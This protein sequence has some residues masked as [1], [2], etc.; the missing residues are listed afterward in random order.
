MASYGIQEDAKLDR[1][2]F[3]EPKMDVRRMVRYQL[4]GSEKRRKKSID[5]AYFHARR[6][7]QK[8]VDFLIEKRTL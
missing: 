2:C 6:G 4:S 8:A 3:L 7:L 5:D 1:L